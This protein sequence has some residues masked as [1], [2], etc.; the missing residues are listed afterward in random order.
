MLESTNAFAIVRAK[1]AINQ[2]SPAPPMTSSLSPISDQVS[3]GTPPPCFSQKHGND[4]KKRKPLRQAEERPMK[5]TVNDE[6]NL[7]TGIF[8]SHGSGDAIPKL[9]CEID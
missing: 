2:P 3:S 7:S 8:H 6:Q 4:V 5:V 9:R 1:I